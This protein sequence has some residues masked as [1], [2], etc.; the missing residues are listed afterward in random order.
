MAPSANGLS[1]KSGSF[2]VTEPYG[3]PWPVTGIALLYKYIWLKTV[4]RTCVKC[5]NSIPNKFRSRFESAVAIKAEVV[6]YGHHTVITYC[7]RTTWAMLFLK[8]CYHTQ[9]QDHHIGVKYCPFHYKLSSICQS[10]IGSYAKFIRTTL[11]CTRV[12]QYSTKF[13]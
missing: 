13:T 1:R 11:V 4:L 10:H 6:S 12:A 9:I 3:S 8:N 7:A 5:M 2:D